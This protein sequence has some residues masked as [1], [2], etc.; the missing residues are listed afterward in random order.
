MLGMMGLITGLLASLPIIIYF[1]YFPII[2]KGE[3]ASLMEDWGWEAI[4]PTASLGPYLYSQAVIVAIMIIL[5][6]IY[7]LRKIDGLKEMEAPGFP[8]PNL[9]GLMRSF[10]MLKCLR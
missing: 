7:P 6:T 2:L 4:M 1:H 10:S 8:G 5:A 9:S 3:M